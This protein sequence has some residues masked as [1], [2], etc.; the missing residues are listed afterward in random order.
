MALLEK[1]PC[2]V[3][4]GGVCDFSTWVVAG[5]VLIVLTLIVV[6]GSPDNHGIFT[7][8]PL[9]YEH[10]WPFVFLDRYFPPPPEQADPGEEIKFL[11]DWRDKQ[12][13]R[14]AMSGGELWS[15]DG[16][17]H[18]GPSWLDGVR[19]PL[20][21]ESLV[22]VAG[23]VLDLAVTFVILVAVA[24]IYEWWARMRWRYRLR[25]L[26]G[27]GFLIAMG[28]AWWQLSIN[29]FDRESQVIVALRNK[30]LDVQWSSGGPVWLVQL[31]GRNH[32]AHFAAL[33]PSTDTFTRTRRAWLGNGPMSVRLLTAT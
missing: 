4:L 20:R 1:C 28:L 26:L 5:L 11:R 22:S 27:A 15:E 9:F 32:L 31:V 14:W 24:C 17:L 6:P 8:A 7:A 12:G 25:C 30:G 10:G 29:E 19:W 2:R 18:D 13:L 21:G 3:A 33:Y 23:L 16:F